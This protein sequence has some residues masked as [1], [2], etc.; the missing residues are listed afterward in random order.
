M[1]ILL[2]LILLTWCVCLAAQDTDTVTHSKP[3]LV[4]S[5]EFEG[6]SL[7]YSQW[8]VAVDAFGGG[9][10]E[11]QIY[12]DRPKNVRVEDGHLILE[13]FRDH[14]G[15]SGTVCE[16][17]SGKIRTK[18]RGDWKYGRIEVRAKL[19]MGQGMWPA[20]WMLPT[21]DVYGGWAASGEI[22][23]ME[24]RGQTPNDTPIS[25]AETKIGKWAITP[26]PDLPNVLILGDSISIGYTPQLRQE[27]Q[28]KANV[29][30]PI[31][32]NGERPE[33]C[34]GT[35]KGI[36]AIDRW[37]EGHDWDVIHF[38]FGLHDLKHVR[39]AGGSKVSN[40]MDDPRQADPETYRKNLRE[41][42]KRLK[43]TDAKLIYATT[44]GYP[45]GVSPAR[46]PADAKIYNDIAI[47]IMDANDIEIDDLHA[48]CQNRLDELQLPKNVHF[49]EQ[50]QT[51]QAQQVA[52]VI[53]RALA[54][55]VH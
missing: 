9:N 18:Y 10:D 16:F 14:A 40:S 35:T 31:S 47:E 24:Y 27:L 38:N 43:A 52:K 36:I 19:P 4:W 33:N 44:T 46:L 34:D 32:A 21:D 13:A 7:D 12:T 42:V 3:K 6:D 17:S 23:I 1:P 45:A 26:D 11:L 2:T 8:G 51:V 53:E 25:K 15:I 29:Y 30:R 54:D 37:L 5:D 48:L 28:G 20:I 50:G 39:E 41:I 49:N 22:D 55:P